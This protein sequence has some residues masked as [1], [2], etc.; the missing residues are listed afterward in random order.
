MQ[1]R[2]EIVSN[3]HRHF[4]FYDSVLGTFHVAVTKDLM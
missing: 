1:V 3:T 2:P 4:D